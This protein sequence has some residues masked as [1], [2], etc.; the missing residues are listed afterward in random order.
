MLSKTLHAK[1]SIVGVRPYRHAKSLPIAEEFIRTFHPGVHTFEIWSSR[2]LKVI[3][4]SSK[5][6]SELKKKISSFYPSAE[7]YTPERFFIDFEHEDYCVAKAYLEKAFFPIRTDIADYPLNTL[8]T[9]MTGHEAVYQVIFTPAQS[10]YTNKIIKAS[11][12]YQQGRV[13]G[14]INPRIVPAGKLEKEYLKCWLRRPEH[15]CT[16]LK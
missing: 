2:K 4:C 13:E 3:L 7:T 15:H 6:E 5:S 14:W 10:K 16:L 1:E 9:C 12:S 11:K 8:L